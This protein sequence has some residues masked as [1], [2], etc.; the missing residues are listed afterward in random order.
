MGF[1]TLIGIFIGSVIYDGDMDQIKKALIAL[2]SYC[3]MLVVSTLTRVLPQIPIVEPI[4]TYQLFAGVTTI[5]IVTF[6]YLLGMFLG[7]IITKKA[8]EEI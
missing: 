5:L 3:L 1:T 8:H 2:S 7:V 6:F 4:K